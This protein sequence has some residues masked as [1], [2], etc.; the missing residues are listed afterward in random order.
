MLEIWRTIEFLELAGNNGVIINF[1][2]LQ[3]SQTIVDSAGFRIAEED[4]E[5]LPK[6]LDAI[7]PFP[8]PSTVTDIRIWFGLV[9]Q[10]AHYAQLRNALEPFRKF[11]SP[12]VPFKSE[13]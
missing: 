6:Y 3:F 13:N 8:N 2:R 10:V 9:K 7:R 5:P 1:K 12:K 4:I 11:L